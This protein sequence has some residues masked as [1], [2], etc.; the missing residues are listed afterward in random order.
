MENKQNIC[1]AICNALK[2][3]TAAGN[4]NALAEL[5]YI[6]KDNGDELVRP[7]F[8]NGAGKNGYYD[9]NVSGDSGIGMWLDITEQFVRKVW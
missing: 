3:T 8:E 7:V 6:V 5:Q 2:A 4:G 9:V 1:D